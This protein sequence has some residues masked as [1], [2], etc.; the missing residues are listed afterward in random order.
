MR[1]R[2]L[3]ALASSLLAAAMVAGCSRPWDAS[4]SNGEVKN[5]PFGQVEDPARSPRYGIPASRGGRYGGSARAA[6]RRGPDNRPLR[7]RRP[8]FEEGIHA[9]VPPNEPAALLIPG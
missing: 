6:G 7:P 3:A 1:M 8:E 9:D 5:F 2:V 4:R